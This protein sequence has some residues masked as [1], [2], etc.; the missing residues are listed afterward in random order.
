[1]TTCGFWLENE[2]VSTGKDYSLPRSQQSPEGIN[3]KDWM[4]V[5]RSIWFQFFGETLSFN[6]VV[7]S[8]CLVWYFKFNLSIHSSHQTHLELTLMLF[9]KE[10]HYTTI[11]SQKDI[12]WIVSPSL[13]MLHVVLWS[14]G[15]WANLCVQLPLVPALLEVYCI[16]YL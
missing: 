2:Q 7:W 8:V 10:L 11:I 14:S 15:C 16:F 12:V 5:I 4:I 1:M 13:P 9:G 3:L 6:F